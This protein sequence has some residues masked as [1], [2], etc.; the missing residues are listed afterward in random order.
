MIFDARSVWAILDGRKTQTRRI[1]KLPRSM[2][3]GDL[4]R[5]TPDLLFGVTSGLR[6]PCSDGTVR[7]LL[8]PWGLHLKDSQVILWVREAWRTESDQYNDLSP[9]QLSGEET[10]LYDADHD[11]IGANKTVGR[12]RSPLHMPRLAS[13]INLLVTGVR[14]ERLLDITWQDAQAEGISYHERGG[15]TRSFLMRWDSIHGE[16]SRDENPWVWVVTFKRMKP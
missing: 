4:S 16:G 5:A 13:R 3:M 1:V 7:P 12:A 9:S 15:Y 10:I 11:D 14:A 2:M 8:S 6:V